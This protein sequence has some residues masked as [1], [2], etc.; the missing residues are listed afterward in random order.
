MDP[1]QED[2]VDEDEGEEQACNSPLSTSLSW[3]T[4]VVPLVP[5]QWLLQHT[6]NGLL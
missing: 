1:A 4:C 2:G 3:N 6:V 5:R